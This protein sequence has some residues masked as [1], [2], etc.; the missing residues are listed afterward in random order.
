MWLICYVKV[1]CFDKSQKVKSEKK[2]TFRQFYYTFIEKPF[3]CLSRMQIVSIKL[4]A[5]KKSLTADLVQLDQLF[6]CNWINS[7]KIVWAIEVILPSGCMSFLYICSWALKPNAF[8]VNMIRLRLI[9][10]RA[11][12]CSFSVIFYF[13]RCLRFF[14][15]FIDS[16]TFF[17]HYICLLTFSLH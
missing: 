16:L 2:F 7:T 17:L 10:V 12:L 6:G 1:T 15:S 11:S 9:R 13:F 5:N 4:I 8:T 3:Q 14:I